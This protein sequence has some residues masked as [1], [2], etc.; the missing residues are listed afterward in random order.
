MIYN[1]ILL[2]NDYK[3][4]SM[5]FCKKMTGNV[6]VRGNVNFSDIRMTYVIKLLLKDKNC[7]I[8]ISAESLTA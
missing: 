7:V 5:F 4:K 1:N 3:K 2:Y 8:I 6:C